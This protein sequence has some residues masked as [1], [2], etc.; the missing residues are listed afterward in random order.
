MRRAAPLLVR[1]LMVAGILGALLVGPCAAEEGTS[2]RAAA[3]E[4][5]HL[6]WHAETL[7]GRVVA[8][9]GGDHPFNPAS[10]V[11]VA[12]SLEALDRLGPGYRWTTDI[13]V[14]GEWDHA[15]GEVSGALVVTGGGDPD[16]QA[17]NLMLIARA[18]N[19]AGVRRVYGG[20]VVR[21]D[22]SVGWEHGEEG[23][24]EDPTARMREMGFR[25]RAAL[26]PR[27]WD[28]TKRA[29]WN[30]LAARRG[31]DR[32]TPPRIVL[33]GSTTYATSDRVRPVLR[34]LSNPLPVVLRRFTVYSNND[35]IRVAEPVGAAGVERWLGTHLGAAGGELSLETAS[36]EGTNRMTPRLV[37]RMLRLARTETARH[38]LALS[39]VL[40]VTGCDP[41]PLSHAL[42]GIPEGA[43]VGKTGTL[44]TTDGGVAVLSGVAA[45]V[46]DGGL[47]FCVAAPETRG[48]TQRWRAAEQ[49]WLLDLL[50]ALGGAQSGACPAEL[51]FSDADAR[52]VP[53]RNDE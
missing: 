23:R 31:W 4:R 19:E 50:A 44:L 33:M 6:L 41:G 52:V 12:T 36:G 22:L 34:H 10:V 48:H 7:D 17:E 18:L 20:L 49:R 40:P 46:G 35:I 26:D 29:V 47:V 25:V 8:S 38:G 30:A 28:H 2:A 16:L 42:A 32:T 13:G 15:R 9:H 3:G 27:R 14:T 24:L 51:P 21:G 11:K 39:D 43:V 37:V 53:V 1:P 45:G 5:A